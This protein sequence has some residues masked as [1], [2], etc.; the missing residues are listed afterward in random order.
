MRA[1]ERE[2]GGERKIA[3]EKERERGGRRERG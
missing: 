3:I 2:K 1:N